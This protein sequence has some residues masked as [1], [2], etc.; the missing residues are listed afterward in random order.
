[1]TQHEMSPT[2]VRIDIQALRG[3]A[4]MLVVLHHAKF[5][6]IESGYLGVDVFFVISGFLITT[7]IS[8]QIEADRFRFSEFYFRRAKRLLPTAYVVLFG[9]ALVATQFLS[10]ME[11]RDLV[12]QIVGAVSLTTNFVL[13]QQ[14]GYFESASELKPLLHFW[15]LA[16]EEQYYLILPM[17]LVL[18]SRRWWL[19]AGGALTAA[20]FAL[21]LIAG[22]WKPIA[23]FYLL[24][25]RAWE[26]GMGS[27][28][29]LVVHVD[30]LKQFARMGFWPA[31]LCLLLL[32]MWSIDQPHPGVVTFFLCTATCLIILRQHPLLNE[33]AIA[34]ATSRLGNMSY[35]LYLVHWPVFAFANNAW[36]GHPRGELPWGVRFGGLVLSVVLGYLLYR[37]VEV[38][39]RRAGVSSITKYSCYL[40]GASLF[41]VVLSVSVVL[42]YDDSVQ[43]DARR[44]N[45]GFDEVCE[46]SDHFFSRPECRS[47]DQPSI[48]VWGDSYAMHLVGGL[49]ATSTAGIVQATRSMCGPLLGLAPIDMRSADGAGSGVQNTRL[50][51]ESCIRFNESVSA[52]LSDARSIDV[53]VVSSR[54]DQYLDKDKFVNLL[55]NDGDGREIIPNAEAAMAALG[56]TVAMVRSLGKRVVVVAPPPSAAFDIGACLERLSHG[57]MN[58]GAPEDCQI[59]Q[60]AYVKERAAVIGFLRR[61]RVELDVGVFSFDELLCAGDHCATSMDGTVIYRDAGHF[62]YSGSRVVAARASLASELDKLAR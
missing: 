62:S 50:W 23:S 61:L 25:T 26:L 22:A 52:Y 51:A 5:P 11:Y 59:H 29:A 57:K 48:L 14:T 17:T 38:P 34:R 58:L 21:C 46:F 53:V 19:L 60:R 56:R 2:S 43:D 13:W 33:H 42:T 1:M 37:Y 24:P 49:R 32:P 55:G 36:I 12:L 6:E 31:M 40:M 7:I 45:F 20:S 9:T 54:L 27:L 41:L 30:R 35:S 16:I 47:A 39:T 15:S 28:L 18:L 10:P 3:L 8:K 44:M 4:V